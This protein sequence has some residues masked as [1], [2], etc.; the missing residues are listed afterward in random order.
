VYRKVSRT[1]NDF[2]PEQMANLSAIVW[3]YRGQQERFLELVRRYLAASPEVAKV[4]AA[5]A[6]FEFP[7]SS[8]DEVFANVRM[9]IEEKE[10][11]IEGGDAFLSA[12]DELSEAYQA[13]SGDRSKLESAVA[14]FRNKHGD[15]A[16]ANLTD[17]HAARKAFDPI[18]EKLRGIV[19][20]VDLVSKLT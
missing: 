10:S 8:V 20:Q 19:R 7:F 17:L 16:S 4:G 3:L 6:S 14:K 18:A 12:A 5:L 9:E 2:A 13:Y 15:L 1:I 11:G